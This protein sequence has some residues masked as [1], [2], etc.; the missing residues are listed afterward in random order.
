MFEFT[1]LSP[2]QHRQLRLLPGRYRI[3]GTGGVGP[4]QK[5]QD[6]SG[7]IRIEDPWLDCPQTILTLMPSGQVAIENLGRPILLPSGRRINPGQCQ[8]LAPPVQWV[9]GKTRLSVT[10]SQ[11]AR[12]YD[13]TLTSLTRGTTAANA[14]QADKGLSASPAASTLVQWFDALNQLQAALVGS[15]A[16]YDQAVQCTFDPAGL[17][18]GMLLQ[19][20]DDDWQIVASHIP[21]PEFG[22]AFRR[23]LVQQVRD[24]R[25]LW[26]HRGQDDFL[27]PVDP[28]MQWVVAAPI[29]DHTQEVTA[30]L[31]ASRFESSFNQRHG[32]RP[33]EAHFIRLVA[34]AV[35][36]AERRRTAQTEAARAHVLL[37]QA[38]APQV[39]PL[40][41]RDPQLLDSRNTEVTILFADLRGFSQ[42]SEQ[43]G[44]ALTHQ[45]LSDILNRW[46]QTVQEFQGVVIDYYGDGLAAFWNC[47]V[48]VEHH[49]WLACQTAWKLLGEL[50]I[51]NQ[52][53]SSRLPRPLSAG[54]GI[55]TGWAHVGNSG[56][57]DKLKYGPRGHAVNL[58][59]RLESATKHF[60]VPILLSET[61]A[62]RVKDLCCPIKLC[63]T[64][65]P[66]IETPQTVY[67]LLELQPNSH[68]IQTAQ[69]YSQALVAFEQGEWTTCLDH[70][71]Q[72]L[73]LNAGDRRADYLLGQLEAQS[74]GTELP[75]LQQLR[76]A[77]P[78][79]PPSIA[80]GQPFQAW[81]DAQSN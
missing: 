28:S 44:A 40:L 14:G 61:T 73:L 70:L 22:F 43:L 75:G 74:H 11:D 5:D 63:Q 69:C 10:L 39:V 50:E 79:P 53:W 16:F 81:H 56:S 72:L 23:D 20:H 59:S 46:T 3:H 9:I 48:I 8:T 12:L 19:W 62:S 25:Q 49:P 33:L 17:D 7:E 57:R 52:A 37:Q 32:I 58:A 65:L 67:Q 1:W 64:Q 24:T 71:S 51:V 80:P 45:L 13:Q 36:A 21:F 29:F 27:A 54:V 34:D 47:P 41:E 30:V 77:K 66:G 4:L 42:L 68:S 35:S 18:L 60:G 26:F 38:F 31:Y 15:Q 2:L 76:S 55:N 6:V 78:L